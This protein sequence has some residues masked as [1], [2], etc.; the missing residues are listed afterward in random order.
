MTATLHT[1]DMRRSEHK[2]S[3]MLQYNMLYRQSSTWYSVDKPGEAERQVNDGHQEVREYGQQ[4]ARS[5]ED[6][7]VPGE[8]EQAPVH[9]H[10][11]LYIN[12]TCMA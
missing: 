8:G 4:Q 6:A 9:Y 10:V 3:I 5:C 7:P 1:E 12:D 11:P 2:I